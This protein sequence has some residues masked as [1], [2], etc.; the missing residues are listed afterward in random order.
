[1]RRFCSVFFE[2]YNTMHQKTVCSYIREMAACLGWGDGLKRLYTIGF[3]GKKLREFIHLLQ[4]AQVTRVVDIRLHNTSQLAGYAKKDDLEYVLELVGIE[5][6]HMPELAPDE[7]LFHDYKKKAI[8]WDTFEKRYRT[9]LDERSTGS[10]CTDILGEGTPAYLCSEEKP[11]YCHRRL[12]TDYLQQQCR[13]AL[14][15][16]HL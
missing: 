6:I 13:Q 1:M 4:Q 2:S 12:L 3:S 14:E 8:D 5:Y 11:R 15:V 16:I 9:L 7:A 10:H